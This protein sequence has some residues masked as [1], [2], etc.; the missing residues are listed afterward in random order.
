MSPV[1]NALLLCTVALCCSEVAA[2]SER[3]DRAAVEPQHDEQLAQAEPNTLAEP[4]ETTLS[5]GTQV[6]VESITEHA[7]G[8]AT[9]AGHVVDREGTVVERDAAGTVVTREVEV[10]PTPGEWSTF[11]TSIGNAKGLGAMG[12]SALVAQGSLLLLRTK[13]GDL[14][15]RAKFL[16]VTSLTVVAGVT[17]LR[18]SGLDWPSSLMHSSTLAAGQVFVHQ[19]FKQFEPP[20]AT[21]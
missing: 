5:D 8:T 19:L 13:V 18:I 17:S 9:Y 4:V 7:D 21:A 1:R 10:E 12:V 3:S 11:L 2:A 14:T 6:V 16:L 20:K 15:G